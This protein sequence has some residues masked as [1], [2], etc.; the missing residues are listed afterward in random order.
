MKRIWIIFLALLVIAIVALLLWIERAQAPVK[1]EVTKKGIDVM[2]ISETTTEKS[3]T[4]TFAGDMMFDRYVNHAFK[5]IGFNHIFDNLDKTLFFDKD[6]SFANLEG[7]VSDQPIV[8]DFP[9][10]SLIFDMPPET[11]STIKN[12]GING[13]SLANNHTMNAGA[14]GFSMTQNLLKDN[15]LK[16]GGYQNDFDG[17]S[18]VRYETEVPT[19]IVAVDY[20]SYKNNAKINEAISAEKNLDRFVII[21]P[22][23][24]E[25]YALAHNSTQE[26]A[27]KNWIDSG[28]DL[29]IGSHPH[30]VQ[31]IG[32]YKNKLIIYS[33]GNFVFDQTF[34]KDTQE[35]L[36]LTGRIT[37]TSLEVS[38]NPV[39]S[40]S[41]KP[42]LAE[43]KVRGEMLGR[44]LDNTDLSD[45][46]LNGNKILLPR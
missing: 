20:L 18:I 36:I 2:Q 12:L 1:K 11:I 15:A 28:A 34:S 46:V 41:L 5:N 21:F 37:E 3:T 14:S 17:G 16:Y 31:D 29:I 44:I 9:E 8:D 42:Q 26:N 10:R 4:F 13:V 43:E 45:G 22:H 6:V 39:E 23:W 7:P 24:G 33:L 32:I 38:L 40:K 35:G 19:S 25:E 27:A 30:V